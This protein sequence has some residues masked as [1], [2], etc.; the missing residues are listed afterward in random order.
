MANAM[1]MQKKK[2]P[3]PRL[4]RHGV[5][6]PDNMDV[7][8]NADCRRIYQE[9]WKPLLERPDGSI[10]MEQLKR[11]L[12]DY[13][14]MLVEVPKVY[15]EVTGNQLSKPLYDAAVVIRKYEEHNETLI[16]DAINDFQEEQRGE[17]T[18]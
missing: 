8:P 15:C 12:A 4:K 14:K 5:S 13:Y 6:S 18:K 17:N 1:F 9:F 3:Q 16:Q 7:T 2:K 11:E 10:K